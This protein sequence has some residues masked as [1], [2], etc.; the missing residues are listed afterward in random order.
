MANVK[1]AW[2]RQGYFVLGADGL[3]PA[4]RDALEQSLELSR[5]HFSI[6][7]YPSRAK[8]RHTYWW[9]E[10][11]DPYAEAQFFA[12]ISSAYP[13]LSL[14]VAVEK[15]YTVAPPGVVVPLEQ[16]MTANWDWHRVLPQMN[17]ILT[18]EVTAVAETVGDVTL[19][20]ATSTPG[21]DLATGK[22]KRV[23]SSK[24]F[25]HAEG[26]W[27]ERYVGGVN[28]DT[29]IA[30]LQAVDAKPDVWAI[31]H[32]A[33]DLTPTTADHLTAADLAHL[34]GQFDRARRRLHGRPVPGDS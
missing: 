4:V 25:T 34:L 7:Y 20:I 16:M 5:G 1:A 19:R 26:M 14:G 33:H 8:W 3:M 23:W 24:A 18:E 13:V 21:S 17:A 10:G 15:G 27:H 28:V 9:R 29:I 2:L 32:L 30:Y 6:H 22:P 11:G 12:Q 31:V